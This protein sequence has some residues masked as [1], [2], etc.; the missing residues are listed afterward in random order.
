[1]KQMKNTGGRAANAGEITEFNEVDRVV[2]NQVPYARQI[3]TNWRNSI[4]LGSFLALTTTV[5]TGSEAIGALSDQQRFNAGWLLGIGFAMTVLA[6]ACAIRASFGWTTPA[7]VG[8]TG[9]LRAWREQEVFA[10]QLFLNLSVVLTVI[11]LV[12]LACGVA[13]VMFHIPWFWDFPGW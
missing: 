7:K 9:G 11:A 4:G 10:T 1:M 3:A 5:M 8:T 6:L 12:A 2:G 13:A